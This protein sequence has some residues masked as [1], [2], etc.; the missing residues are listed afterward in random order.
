MLCQRFQLP[1]FLTYFIGLNRL[2]QILIPDHSNYLTGSRNIESGSK[3]S[4]PL[5]HLIWYKLPFVSIRCS[6]KIN[7]Q[8]SQNYKLFLCLYKIFD[9]PVA[10]IVKWNILKSYLCGTYS[11]LIY[12]SLNIVWSW[13]FILFCN[14]YLGKLGQSYVDSLLPNLHFQ[15]RDF[16]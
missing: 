13:Y 6:I 11:C 16:E 2:K 3:L 14:K 1:S 12:P 4:E 5:S 8:S 15:D 9:I 10:C 7:N